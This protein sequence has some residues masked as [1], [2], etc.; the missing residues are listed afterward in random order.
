MAPLGAPAVE[1]NHGAGRGRR[2]P[3]HVARAVMW[4]NPDWRVRPM[5]VFGT[6]RSRDRLRVFL[7][8]TS[9]RIRRKQ[10]LKA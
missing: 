7:P 4:A 8:S 10:E 9:K 2:Q 6:K 5:S 1:R 3:R